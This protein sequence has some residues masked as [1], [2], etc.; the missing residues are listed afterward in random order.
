MVECGNALLKNGYKLKIL[1]TIN[2]SKSMH[3][4]PFAYVH[5]E[6][7]ILKLVTTL[8]TNTKGDGSGGDPFWEKSERLLLTALIAYLHYE[9]PVEEQN[10]ATLLEMLNTM[11]VLED[12]EEYQNPVDLLFEELAKK[13]PN[14]FAGRQYKGCHTLFPRRKI[15][16]DSC[17]VPEAAGNPDT[18]VL[19]VKT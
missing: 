6:K 11:Q 2:F 16:R 5:S 8:M 10:F 19:S 7:D 1:N 13:K 9:A 17:S 15:C 4:N 12:D 3:Y 18:A 14:S